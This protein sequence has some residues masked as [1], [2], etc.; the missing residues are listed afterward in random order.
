MELEA[1]N[2]AELMESTTLEC[3]VTFG[4][5]E[6]VKCVNTRKE[7]AQALQALRSP[8]DNKYNYVAKKCK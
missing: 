3:L 1:Q 6:T 5:I 7:N 2:G 8:I 4:G